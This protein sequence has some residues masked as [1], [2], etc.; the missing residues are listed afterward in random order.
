MEITEYLGCGCDYYQIIA[1]DC[2]PL[3]GMLDS[4]LLKAYD[5]ACLCSKIEMPILIRIYIEDGGKNTS[6]KKQEN[7]VRNLLIIKCGP[8]VTFDLIRHN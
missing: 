3:V 7:Y 5:H 1:I 8:Y 4:K 6:K 2:I